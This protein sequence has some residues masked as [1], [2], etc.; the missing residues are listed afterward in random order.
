M[1]VIVSALPVPVSD[2]DVVGFVN[3]IDSKPPSIVTS[4][5][6][7]TAGEAAPRAILCPLV[8]LTLIA[9]LVTV[10]VTVTGESCVKP[11]TVPS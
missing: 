5:S 6:P 11:M 3:V 10:L 8:S 2:S 9:T 4:D 1:S 7:A